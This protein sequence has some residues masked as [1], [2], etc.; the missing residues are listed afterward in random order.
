[1][2]ITEIQKQ[3]NRNINRHE[4]EQLYADIAQTAEEKEEERKK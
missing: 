2:S 4:E 3:T 1:M